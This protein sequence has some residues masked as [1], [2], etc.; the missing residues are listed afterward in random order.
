MRDVEA[1]RETWRRGLH[2]YPV[3]AAAQPNAGHRAL[4]ELERMGKLSAV[5]TQNIDG[6]HQK[7]GHAAERV[8]ELHGSAHGVQCLDCGARFTRQLVHDRV[9]SG[10]DVPAC[11][12]CG[13]ILK[14]TTVSFGE[15]MPVD[16][17]RL[18]E[19][20]ARAADLF[21]VIGSS[22]VVFPA[23]SL[24]TYA[25]EAGATLAILNASETDLDDEAAVVLRG[26]AGELLPPIVA[27]AQRLQ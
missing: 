18:A 27:A 5:I 8:I 4:V 21:I 19:R 12:T 26:R 14:P 16:E 10:E 15:A 11:S 9:V 22:L 25:L 13:G 23:A 1:R 17:L 7:A 3:V 24:P 20:A 6:L 2:T